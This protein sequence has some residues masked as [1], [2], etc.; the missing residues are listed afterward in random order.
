VP[1]G[2]SEIFAGVTFSNRYRSLHFVY[3]CYC[4]A[5]NS[6]SIS[7]RPILAETLVP[8]KILAAVQRQ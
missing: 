4:S 3:I 7:S 5:T 1:A 2:L 6:K 8:S